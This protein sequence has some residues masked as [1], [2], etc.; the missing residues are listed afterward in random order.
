[1]NQE[2]IEQFKGL[3]HRV[4]DERDALDKEV[5]KLHHRFVEDLIK[6]HEEKRQRREAIKRHVLGWSIVAIISSSVYVLGD[7]ALHLIKK[8][9]G[10]DNTAQHE[11]VLNAKDRRPFDE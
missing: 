5:H 11:Q 4:L 3:I 9:L 8:M 1:M 10:Q 7:G 2:D 6:L